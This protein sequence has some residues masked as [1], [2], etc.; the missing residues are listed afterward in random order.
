VDY[1][2]RAIVTTNRVARGVLIGAQIRW[3]P[4]I[5]ESAVEKRGRSQLFRQRFKPLVPQP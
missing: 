4:A 1:V 2:N 3:N 5:V